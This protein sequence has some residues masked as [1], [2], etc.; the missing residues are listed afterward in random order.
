MLPT[1]M[2][3]D[4]PRGLKVVRGNLLELMDRGLFDVV[5]HGCNC[6]HRMGAGLALDI[7]KRYPAV[8][9]A[10]RMES[11]LGD[12]G[13]LGRFTTASV[14]TSSGRSLVIANLYTQYYYGR[15]V[16]GVAHFK[17]EYLERALV[18]LIRAFPERLIAVP[19]IGTGFGGGNVEEVRNV[20]ARLQ[21]RN[22]LLV[23]VEQD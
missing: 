11:V 10:D 6:F 17:L 19:L 23:L 7:S 4:D 21:R 2:C 5:A 20:V 3:H 9:R 22:A 15:P 18:N 8:L 13:K 1:K 12:K 16:N 14:V